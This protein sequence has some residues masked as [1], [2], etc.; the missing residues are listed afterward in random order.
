MTI[1]QK[2]GLTASTG[3]VAFALMASSAFASS[4]VTI[5]GNGENSH[6][7]VTLKNHTKTTFN[8]SNVSGISTWVDSSA[9]T[10]HNKANSN[11]GGDVTVASGNADS[12]VS[13]TTGGSSNDGF[14]PSP[15][16]CEN[17]GIDVTISGNGEDSHN[18]VTVKGGNTTTVNQSNVSEISTWVDSSA[19]TGHNS[20]NGNTGGDVTVASGDAS[21][22]VGVTTSGSSNSLN[23]AI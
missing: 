1:T 14:L 7:H 9:S 21:S 3:I 8:Q 23:S 10:G 12:T 2:I 20:A 4:S 6:N 15:C 19:S 16:G 18:H 13:V 11:T 22:T 17:G 5:T